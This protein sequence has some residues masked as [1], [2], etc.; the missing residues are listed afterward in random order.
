[1]NPTPVRYE[2]AVERL[3]PARSIALERSLPVKRLGGRG[4]RRYTERLAPAFGSQP[5][6]PPA[7]VLFDPALFLIAE[8]WPGPWYGA[9]RI[10]SHGRSQGI[11]VLRFRQLPRTNQ[12]IARIVHPL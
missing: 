10:K 12:A 2:H 1:M 7:L 5:F 9:Q 11:D 8:L 6:F 4:V 3:R